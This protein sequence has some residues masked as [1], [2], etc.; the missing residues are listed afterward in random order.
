VIA[1]YIVV[2]A[3]APRLIRTMTSFLVAIGAAGKRIKLKTVSQ[4]LADF[5]P[6]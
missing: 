6:F 3:I 5:Q 4:I 2:R 1:P